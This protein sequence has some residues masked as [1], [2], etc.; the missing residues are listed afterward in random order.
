MIRLRR[1]RNN[2]AIR[3]LVQET[4]LNIDQ[5]IHPIFVKYGHNIKNHIESMPGYYQLSLDRLDEEIDEIQKLG[6]KNI[7]LFGIPEL[8]DP[9]GL[10]AG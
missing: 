6:I 10:K 2:P 8:K 1:L 5:F 9:L 4:H 3:K 7:I